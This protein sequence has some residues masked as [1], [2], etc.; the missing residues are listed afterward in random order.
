VPSPSSIRRRGILVQRGIRIHT[1]S[2]GE[3]GY[4][5]LQSSGTV[6]CNPVGSLP[7]EDKRGQDDR[8]HLVLQQHAREQI[9]VLQIDFGRVDRRQLQGVANEA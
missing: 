7:A 3:H 1:D 2:V 6:P 4:G 9:H 8:N 5:L